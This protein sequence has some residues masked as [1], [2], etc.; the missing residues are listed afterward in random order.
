MSTKSPFTVLIK[1]NG[2]NPGSLGFTWEEKV[3]ATNS[4]EA[5]K[6]A[7]DN[8]ILDSGMCEEDD[9]ENLELLREDYKCFAVYLGH[10][11]NLANNK[12]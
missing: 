8:I 4:C 11:E 9:V 2:D 5:E 7:I 6:T 1:Y 3:E 12:E 10:L